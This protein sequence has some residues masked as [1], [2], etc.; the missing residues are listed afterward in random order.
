MNDLP[1]SKP[2]AKRNPDSD[3]VY[4]VWC[5]MVPTAPAAT[6]AT[7][8]PY[9]GCCGVTSST[10]R[11]SLD[12]LSESPAQ[13]NRYRVVSGAVE[14]SRTVAHAAICTSFVF[15]DLLGG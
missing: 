5:G 6:E 9:V 13:T 11:K 8:R 12:F 1:D 3:S 14:E 10:A 4:S 15:M 2:F 7:T